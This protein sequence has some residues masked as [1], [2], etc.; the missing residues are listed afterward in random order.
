MEVDITA[1][2][3]RAVKGGLLVL[4][5]LV[6]VAVFGVKSHYDGQTY[7]ELDEAEVMSALVN[8][9]VKADGKITELV[10]SD[11]D[12][13]AAGDVLARLAVNVTAEEIE[14]LAQTVELAKRNLAEVQKGQVVKV[15]TGGGGNGAAKERVEQ[16]AARAKRMAELF[17]MGAVSA[18][19]RDEAQAAYEAAKSEV[20]QAEVTYTTT[21]Q[22][23]PPE[24]IAAAELQV[25]QAEVALA[26]AR[27]DSQFTEVT[28]PVN[29][30]VYLGDV[31]VGDEVKAGTV[32]ARL[33]EAQGFW[34][35]AKVPMAQKESL[36]LGQYA[37][38]E[39]E[40]Q[41]LRGTVQDIQ[42]ESSL[43][44]DAEPDYLRVRLS[45]PTEIAGELKP[46]LTAKVRLRL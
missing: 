10:V 39:L 41:E 8:A 11:G 6:V 24:V 1:Q 25:R 26:T 13:V 33:S 18:V 29:G 22:P 16:A 34:L 21:V 45:V 2:V 12:V 42:P 37:V 5:I 23:S 15:P 27:Q 30:T 20:G 31:A 17:E 38:Y 7:L 44:A 40:G 28:S 9:S 35:E 46:G 32:V 4:V 36:H 43:T 3:A 14:Q 19:K